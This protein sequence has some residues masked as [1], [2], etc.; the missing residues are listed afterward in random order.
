MVANLNKKPTDR[1]QIGQKCDFR[2]HK[3]GYECVIGL[4]S[5][6][7]PEAPKSKKWGDKVDLAV[8]LRDVLLKEGIE[9]NG[10]RSTTFQKLYALGVHSFGKHSKSC[11]VHVSQ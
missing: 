7:L 9:N 4:R 8:A 10:V 5:G 1:G 3:N 6:G 11:E 2:V